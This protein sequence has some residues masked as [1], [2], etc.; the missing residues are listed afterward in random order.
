MNQQGYKPDHVLRAIIREAAANLPP[1]L[2]FK[3]EL[4]TTTINLSKVT[5]FNVRSQ[6][7][8]QSLAR[9]ALETNLDLKKVKDVCQILQFF[10]DDLVD[11]FDYTPE[12]LSGKEKNKLEAFRKILNNSAR[13]V[14]QNTDHFLY[15]P[16][17]EAG[18]REF[19]FL[20][21]PLLIDV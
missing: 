1:S 13:R 10:W 4:S 7:C 18:D 11:D 2:N 9:Q 12:T 17:A 3:P 6:T 5:P 14:R 8:I 15:S 16:R 19:L 21:Y 20:L